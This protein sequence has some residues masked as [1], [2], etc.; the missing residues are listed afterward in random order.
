MSWCCE[1]GQASVELV[2]LAPLLVA[3]V[4]AAAQLLAAGAAGELADHA[5][6]AGAVAILEGGD[7]AAAARDAVP[8]WSRRRMSVRVTGRRVSVRLRP[9]SPIPELAR[10]L[11]A[12]RTAD[13]G[14]LVR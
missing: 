1:R 11:E 12:G 14:P 6:E 8:G 4:L 2:V 13:A 10:M 7:P 9:P 5:A 3:I